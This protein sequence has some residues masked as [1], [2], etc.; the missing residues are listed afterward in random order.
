MFSKLSQ[1]ASDPELDFALEE[2]VSVK[3]EGTSSLLLSFVLRLD[4][5]SL[6][7]LN[8][9][10]LATVIAAIVVIRRAAQRRRVQ[11]T[12]FNL[13]LYGGA[14]CLDID[15]QPLNPVI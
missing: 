11:R 6:L 5:P 14:V 2:S 15:Y 8:L 1:N 3:A 9:V 10:L 13:P 7:V 12:L 4:V